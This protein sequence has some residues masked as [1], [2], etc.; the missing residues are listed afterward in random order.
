MA[1]LF[2]SI[3]SSSTL[4]VEHHLGR[5]A[6]EAN[7]L[8]EASDALSNIIPGLTAKIGDFIKSFSPEETPQHTMVRVAEKDL[9]S[10]K[11]GASYSSFATF[12]RTLVTIPEG[13]VGNFIDYADALMSV[14]REVTLGAV[15]ILN[16]LNNDLAVFISSRENKF[17]SKDK[18]STF[19]KCKERREDI[20]KEL[21]KFFTDKNIRAKAY[22]SEVI[23]RFEDLDIVHA[24]CKKL[25]DLNGGSVLKDIHRKAEEVNRLLE[26]VIEDSR[27]NGASAVSGVAARN[28]AEGAYEAAKA[29]ELVGIYRFRIEQLIGVVSELISRLKEILK[30]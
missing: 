15:D 5:L 6:L 28:I 9:A 2:N 14:S 3:N 13:F 12:D 17:S 7:V 25:L 27:E 24:R 20:T 19:K 4:S 10:V 29:V 18:T 23:G 1:H 8:V 11:V 16:I 26:I 30:K 21:G 22:M